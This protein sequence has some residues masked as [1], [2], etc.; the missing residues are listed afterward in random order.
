PRIRRAQRKKIIKQTA[1]PWITAA[2]ILLKSRAVIRN[3]FKPA[4]KI[5]TIDSAQIIM[6]NFEQNVLFTVVYP[7][8]NNFPQ[9]HFKQDIYAIDANG[10]VITKIRSDY[11][12]AK[13]R[14]D[15][16]HHHLSSCNNAHK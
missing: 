14:I 10:T 7:F 6:K 12:V 13:K 9:P 1:R 4:Y 8:K 16:S 15:F 5:T 2:T 3:R 11:Y